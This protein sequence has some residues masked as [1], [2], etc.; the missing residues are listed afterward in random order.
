MSVIMFD[1]LLQR[2]ALLN[3]DSSTGNFRSNHC[4]DYTGLKSID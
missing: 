4:N 2:S 1:T 3:A